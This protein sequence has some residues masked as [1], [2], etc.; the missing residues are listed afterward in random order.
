MHGN[1]KESQ[2]IW[3]AY[4]SEE[5]KLRG[6]QIDPSQMEPEKGEEEWL[7]K[8]TRDGGEPGDDIVKTVDVELPAQSLNPS[9]SEIY[10]GKALGMAVGGMGNG[11]NLNAIISGDNH[12]LD[13]HHRWAACMLANPEAVVGGKQS[14]L[15]IADLIPVLRGAGVA[16]GN[17]FRGKES[18]TDIN[19]YQ[20]D[21]AEL[22][23]QIEILDQGTKFLKPG[24][25]S[26]FVAS[27]GGIEQLSAR[28]EAIQQKTP[29]ASAPPRDKMPVIDSEGPQSGTNEVDDA[30]SRLNKGEIDVY[31]P[32][33]D[34]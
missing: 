11:G 25:A 33:A 23:K 10:L 20:A 19:V 3:E 17:P 31:P 15:P 32:Y 14:E 9:Q 30:A 4:V 34:K 18:A 16:Y 26:E 22:Q 2:L 1:D 8:G 6:K 21:A 24:Q 13:G 29:P 27:I 12:I 7:T 28:M 5:V